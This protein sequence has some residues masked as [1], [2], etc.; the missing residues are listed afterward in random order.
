MKPE[1]LF[2][3]FLLR[4]KFGVERQKKTGR[5]EKKSLEKVSMSGLL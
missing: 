5:E 3:L 4:E 2:F 1:E